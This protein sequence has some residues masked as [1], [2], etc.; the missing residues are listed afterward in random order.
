MSTLFSY[1]PRQDMELPLFLE[2][3]ACGFP[4][5]AQDYVEDRIDLNKLAVKHPSA[6][7]FVKVSGDS[8]IGAGIGDGDL[9]VVDRSLTAEHG[10]IVV[11]A[12]DGEFTVKELQTRP[13]LRL[14][15]HNTRYQPITFHA[16]EELQIF[17]VVTHTLKTHKQSGGVKSHRVGDP[18][19]H[20]HVRT[21]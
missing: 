11:A 7:Y 21:C 3:V 16:E 8:M 17:G 20:N 13:V 2:R 10:D 15:P 4:S 18:E 5:P 14:L 9:L 1:Y 12:V 6:T 19:M